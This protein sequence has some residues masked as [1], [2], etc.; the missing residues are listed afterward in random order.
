MTKDY[1]IQL[2]IENNTVAMR[3]TRKI[4]E[5]CVIISDAKEAVTPFIAILKM[6]KPL[7]DEVD[8]VAEKAV[9]AKSEEKQCTTTT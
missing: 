3:V 9:L 8:R 1:D 4:G 5:E 2:K 7:L 6:I